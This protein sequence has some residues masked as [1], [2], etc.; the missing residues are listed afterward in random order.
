MAILR[1]DAV[2][3]PNLPDVTQAYTNFG[4]IL[5]KSLG[6]LS[7]GLSTMQQ[8][9]KEGAAGLLAARASG[10]TDVNKYNEALASGSILADID[11]ALLDASSYSALDQRRT[12]LLSVDKLKSS[13][14]TDNDQLVNNKFNRENTA[15]VTDHNIDLDGKKLAQE[16]TKILDAR[17]NNAAQNLNAKNQTSIE[18]RKADSLIKGANQSY[19]QS[20]ANFNRAQSTLA[21]Q[22][23]VTQYSN[24]INGAYDDYG[25]QQR[26]NEV[27]KN[28][29]DPYV[30]AA[31]GA[32]S[33][34]VSQTTGV[35]GMLSGGEG[36]KGAAA[37]TAFNQGKAGDSVGKSLDPNITMGELMKLQQL[38]KGHPNRV[39]AA[40]AMQAIPTTLFG[41]NVDG[42]GGAYAALG[43]TPDTK[44]TPEVQHKVY[45]YLLDKKRP[46]VGAYIRGEST[47]QIKAIDGLAGEFAS[48]ADPN[49]GLSKHGAVGNNKASISW[50]TAGANLDA[51][52]TAYQAAIKSGKS[53]EA[54]WE[55]A[56][57]ITTGDEQATSSAAREEYAAANDVNAQN[58]EKKSNALTN[59][60]VEASLGAAG[61]TTIAD[62]FKESSQNPD[63][64]PLVSDALHQRLRVTD[65]GD[66]ANVDRL[67]TRMADE[68]GGKVSLAVLA[69]S[70]A[71]G[72]KGARDGSVGSVLFD[73]MRPNSINGGSRYMRENEI[74]QSARLAASSAGVQGA[75]DLATRKED[76]VAAKAADEALVSART[77]WDAA[78]KSREMNGDFGASLSDI[79]RYKAEYDKAVGLAS[80]ANEKVQAPLRDADTGKSSPVTGSAVAPTGTEAEKKKMMLDSLGQVL[81]MVENARAGYNFYNDHFRPL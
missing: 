40:G 29:T 23:K 30:L 16:D 25:K 35:V 56:I 5:D 46:E 42:K 8:K 59:S 13:I 51:A 19:D 67:L 18:A 3:A 4:E 50:R 55:T 77:A 76:V 20:E 43:L 48:V 10:F 33:N 41:D 72:T 24:Y 80:L 9:R 69:D 49:T 66:K 2:N 7:N 64:F 58:A 15:R 57:G 11:P 21:Q 38:P 6:K 32:G 36:G 52:R 31:L 37:Y 54:A 14:A 22:D 68:T 53:E 73:W 70:I 17:N 78:I 45:G 62:S 75:L 28:E 81:P 63:D 65:E 47:D 74:L 71:N 60:Y 1:W 27:R 61:S 44:F 12:D 79:A 39:F 26:L 34:S